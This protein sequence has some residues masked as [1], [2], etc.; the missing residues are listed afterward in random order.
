MSGLIVIRF[1]M[2]QS[3]IFRNLNINYSIHELISLVFSNSLLPDSSSLGPPSSTAVAVE[4]STPT[5]PKLARREFTFYPSSYKLPWISSSGK[6]ILAGA[7]AHALPPYTVEE[8]ARAMEDAATLGALMSYLNI[9][10]IPGRDKRSNSVSSMTVSV[11]FASHSHRLSCPPLD[12]QVAAASSSSAQAQAASQSSRARPTFGTD[13]G[14]STA[15]AYDAEQLSLLLSAYQELSQKRCEALT[16]EYLRTR[17]ALWAEKGSEIQTVRDLKF[18]EY[19]EAMKEFKLQAERNSRGESEVHISKRNVEAD[20]T[21]GEGRYEEGSM[22]RRERIVMEQWELRKNMYMY[23]PVEAADEW[24]AAWGVMQERATGIQDLDLDLDLDSV[25][26]DGAE[27]DNDNNIGSEDRQGYSDNARCDPGENEDE[28]VKAN[29][30]LRQSRISK[31]RRSR[32][33]EGVHRVSV[34]EGSY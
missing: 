7:A 25:D 11:S 3:L 28:T 20:R 23:D 10:R 17:M 30:D 12:T 19:E 6:V 15:T 18:K 24:Y 13:S 33:I 31:F 16:K 26:N 21:K 9:R 2:H 29:E 32:V 1:S 4:P 22:L 14:Y 27:G 34:S 8:N 5:S